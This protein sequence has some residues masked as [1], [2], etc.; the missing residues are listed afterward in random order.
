[1]NGVI[2]KHL[3]VIPLL[4]NKAKQLGT[5]ILESFEFMTDCT[6]ISIINVNNNNFNEIPINL[7]TFGSLTTI[8]I[9]LNKRNFSR[10]SPMPNE[11]GEQLKY[12][13][14]DSNNIELFKYINNKRI[15]K[16]TDHYLFYKA[17]IIIV[18]S[19]LD[20]VDCKLQLKF[21]RKNIVFNLLY[22]DQIDSFI[23]MCSEFIFNSFS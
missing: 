7:N 21:M 18:K 8:D 10:N 1:M 22:P 5:G 13:F 4:N 9:S 20:Y 16:Q 3:S 17:L 12:V 19:Q 23:S 15:I 2:S 6:N 11:I 14:I